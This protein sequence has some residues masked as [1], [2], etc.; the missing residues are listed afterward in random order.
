MSGVYFNRRPLAIRLGGWFFLT[1]SVY[2]GERGL[3]VRLGPFSF[4]RAAG[5]G[6][7]TG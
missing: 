1:T 5:S 2:D 6:E 3:Y 4:V 7:G